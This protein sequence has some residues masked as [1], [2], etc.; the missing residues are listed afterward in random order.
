MAY[1]NDWDKLDQGLNLPGF[2]VEGEGPNNFLGGLKHL[3]GKGP[4]LSRF[5]WGGAEISCNF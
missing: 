4:E 2:F 3:F 5:F 1:Q